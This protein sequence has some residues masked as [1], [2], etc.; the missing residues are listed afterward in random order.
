MRDNRDSTRAGAPSGPGSAPDVRSVELDPRL[1]PEGVVPAGLALEPGTLARLDLAFLPQLLD[2]VASG[3]SIHATG[4]FSADHLRAALEAYHAGLERAHA[5]GHDISQIRAIATIDVARLDEV[6]AE[7]G[8]AVLALAR[9]AAD[10]VAAAPRFGELRALGANPMIIEPL[11]SPGLG[12]SE[13]AAGS[14]ADTAEGGP[15]ATAEGATGPAGEDAGATNMSI[16]D[17][18]RLLNELSRS[19]TVFSELAGRL[20]EEARQARLE[21]WEAGEVP[22]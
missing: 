16:E 13:G 2:L 22:R 18:H 7:L 15:D 10:E 14:E 12:T 8:A 3:K 4:V 19:G 11:R 6:E 9:E 1:D 20:A 21:A 17:A 5:A